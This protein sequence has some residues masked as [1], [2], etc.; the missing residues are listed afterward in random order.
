MRK[1]SHLAQHDLL[2][3]LPNRV[4]LLDRRTQA[5]NMTNRNSKQIALLFLDLDHFKQIN[6]AFGHAAGDQLL[7]T[8]AVKIEACVRQRTVLKYG[9]G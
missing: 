5:I 1:M 6:D 2:T 8:V 7:R 9:E 3:G 4:L